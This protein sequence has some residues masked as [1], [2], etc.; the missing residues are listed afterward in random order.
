[1][2]DI[3]RPQLAA[4][5]AVL[6]ARRSGVATPQLLGAASP[7]RSTRSRGASRYWLALAAL[8][9]LGGF[10]LH[11]R[12]PGVRRSRRRAAASARAQAA[13]RIGVGSLVNSFAPAKLG[14][15]VKIAL[16]SRAIDG[17]GRLWTTGGVYAA[18]AAARSLDARGAARRRLGDRRD[19]AL[20]GLRA[21]AALVGVLA[22]AGCVLERLRAHPR[23]ATVARRASRRSSARR[24]RSSTV[25]GWT[26]WMQLRGSPR[27]SPSP[28]ALG[29]AAS[30]CS[31]RS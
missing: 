26:P 15:A 2:H 10:W 3:S 17:P 4:S 5:L 16:C 31:R 9:F 20:A 6:A 25:L 28:S 22:V 21:L 29:A 13:A 11:R 24:A 7:R 1:M 12:S 27:R 30:R 14:D 18:L 8:G 23:I 19:A